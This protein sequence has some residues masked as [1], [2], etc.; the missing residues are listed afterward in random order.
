MKY[1]VT[2]CAWLWTLLVN[3][4]YL[5]IVVSDW[6]VSQVELHIY[7]LEMLSIRS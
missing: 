7:S 5:C 6:R 3:H 2:T 4:F 1:V